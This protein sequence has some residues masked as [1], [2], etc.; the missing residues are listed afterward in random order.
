MLTFVFVCI[1]IQYAHILT[2]K[3]KHMSS[4]KTELQF[5]NCIELN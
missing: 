3:L 1:C 4:P 5:Y 2:S